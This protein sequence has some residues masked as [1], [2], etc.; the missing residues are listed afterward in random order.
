[1]KKSKKI[2]IITGLSLCLGI[3]L[4]LIFKRWSK[5]QQMTCENAECY[6]D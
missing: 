2:G 4:Y 5:V 6:L 3:A 1:M